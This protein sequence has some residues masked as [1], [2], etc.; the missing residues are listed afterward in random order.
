MEVS[1]SKIKERLPEF[2]ILNYSEVLIT[3]VSY[4]SRT[5][6]QGDIF[7]PLEGEHFNGHDFIPQAFE[8]GAIAT[9][10]DSKHVSEYANRSEPIIIV[11]SIEEGLEKIVNILFSDILAP[12]IAI[13]GSTG[14]TTTREMLVQILRNHGRVLSSDCNFNTLWGNAKLLSEYEDEDYIVLELSM[15]RQ[16]EIG[17]QCR[18][19]EPD[20][21]VILNIG[22]VHAENVGGIENIFKGKKDLADYLHRNGKPLVLNVDDYW[23]KKI[24]ANYTYQILT[25]GRTGRDFRLID[26]TV[27]FKGTEFSF[28]C[29]GKKYIGNIKAYGRDLAY[30]ALAAIALAEL[31]SIDVEESLKALKNY[32]AFEGRFEVNN[33][34]EYLTIVNDA[35]N[36]NPSSMRMSIETF[37]E[38]FSKKEYNRILILGDMKDLGDA[39]NEQHRLIGEL[40]KEKSFDKVYYIGDYFGDFGIGEKLINWYQAEV[41]VERLKYKKGEK[42]AVLL[43]SSNSIGLFNIG[44]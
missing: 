42:T 25:Y 20:V 21:G 6:E 22:Y 8:R 3:G 33:V 7:F 1:L 14:K 30:N 40:V 44:K 27:S 28:E 35:Y 37:D 9:L 36:A 15:G 13:T 32:S 38:I 16:G 23:L 19:I 12:I 11:D 5:I 26:A 43:K 2:K 29:D 34:N 10:C 39:S 18:A 41:V 24:E 4:D 31:L 17:W